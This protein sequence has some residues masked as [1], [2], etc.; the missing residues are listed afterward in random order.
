MTDC[1]SDDSGTGSKRLFFVL[2]DDGGSQ[3][4]AALMCSHLIRDSAPLR[5]PVRSRAFKNRPSTPPI[6]LAARQS[7]L[8]SSSLNERSRAFSPSK[9]LSRPVIGEVLTL[10]IAGFAHQAKNVRSRA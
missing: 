9:G 3:N 4:Q 5:L 1:V 2:S 10:P 8:I 6:L 7:A